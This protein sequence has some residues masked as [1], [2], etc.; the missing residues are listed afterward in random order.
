MNSYQG[1]HNPIIQNEKSL[2][3]YENKIQI[4]RFQRDIKPN[5]Q[6]PNGNQNRDKKNTKAFVNTKSKKT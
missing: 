6:S 4:Y 2:G 1:V 5:N 3:V